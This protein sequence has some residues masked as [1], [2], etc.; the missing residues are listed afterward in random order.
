MWHFSRF[1]RVSFSVG[2]AAAIAVPVFCQTPAR[3]PAQAGRRRVQQATQAPSDSAS[4]T[5][6]KGIFEPVNYGQDINLTDVFFVSPDVGWVSGEHATLLK[7]TDGGAHWTAQ[8]G[9][10]PNG[11]EKPIGQLRFLD[12]RHGWAVTDDSPQRLLRTM[13]G[14]NWEQVAEIP[15]EDDYTFVSVRR[16][17]LLRGN[18][19][20]FNVTDD[21]GRHWRK[22]AP[23]RFATTVQGLPQSPACF[24]IKLQMLSARV[25]YVF[26]GWRS[27]EAPN[28]TTIVLFRT[29]DAGEHWN[30]NVTAVRGGRPDGYFIDAEHGVLVFQD[31]T[32]ITSDGGRNWRALLSGGVV[33]DT[34]DSRVR[35][36]DPETG[37]SLGDKYPALALSY[38][39]DGGQHWKTFAPL[40]MPGDPNAKVLS[41]SLPRRDRAYIAGPHGMVYRYRIVPANYTVANAFDVPLMPS[42]GGTELSAK[43]DAIRRDIQALQSKL[44]ALPDASQ[45]PAASAAAGQSSNTVGGSS[46]GSYA[47][48]AG[49]PGTANAAQGAAPSDVAGASGGF[50]QQTDVS[51]TADAIASGT[52]DA[53]APGSAFTQDTSPPSDVL[54]TCCAAAV[55]QLQTDTSGFVAQTAPVTSQLRPLNLVVAG[56]Q[57]AATLMNQGQG[58]WNQFKTLKH[59]PNAQ[60]ASAALQQLSTT[61][62]TVQQAS[63]MGLQNPGAWFAANAPAAFTQDVSTPAAATAGV[64]A[65]VGDTVSG[66]APQGQQQQSSPQSGQQDQSSSTPDQKQNPAQ[67]SVDQ[68]VGKAKQKIKSK[69][70]WPP[71]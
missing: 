49:Q 1:I 39:T 16:G 63:S 44:T 43:A 70:K 55:Q 57:L 7:T 30:Y 22:V 31:K 2:L 4:T 33:T 6:Y 62:N 27:P 15:G 71:L 42:F 10:D 53:S 54:A 35:F 20:G 21:G 17:I 66:G 26:A 64:G 5:Q 19:G 51:A 69:L 38:T 34:A 61:L 40:G 41:L 12:A 52:T 58:L 48:A 23:C 56:L 13:D 11:N 50:T 14:E 37:W 68:A 60:A 18:M 24:F 47:S 28:S 8:I 32:Y 59:A 29:D 67:N 65:A 36:A 25:G 9:G 46:A 45:S 3:R